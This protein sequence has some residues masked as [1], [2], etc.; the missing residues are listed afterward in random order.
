MAVLQIAGLSDEPLHRLLRVDGRGGE[1]LGH[2]RHLL[3]CLDEFERLEASIREQRLPGELMDEIRHIIQHHP[4]I[5]L[6]FA[7]RT[8]RTSST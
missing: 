5:V 6:L 3:L 8:A 1:Q 7:G 2:E 4:R